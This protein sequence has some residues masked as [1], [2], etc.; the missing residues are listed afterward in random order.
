MNLEELRQ[1]VTRRP[2]KAFTVYLDDGFD[3]HVERRDDVLLPPYGRAVMLYR[4]AATPDGFQ[5]LMADVEH[6][7]RVEFDDPATILD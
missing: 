1:V 7:T 3:W 5:G 6:I 4:K 2:F